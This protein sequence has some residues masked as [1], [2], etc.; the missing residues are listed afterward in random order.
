M[1]GSLET[2]DVTWFP[3]VTKNSSM[4]SGYYIAPT[5]PLLVNIDIVNNQK[6]AKELY[7]ITEI[8][9][10]PGKR[11]D[12]LAAEH[13]IMDLGVC[14]GQDGPS[15][16]D[17][18]PPAGQTK[19]SLKGSAAVVVREGWLVNARMFCLLPH[20]VRRFLTWC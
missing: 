2:S 20:T 4:N 16:L 13:R 6:E 1:A 12:V 5:D 7:M 15:G 10:L 19:W 8:E 18:H 3:K 11:K 17:V 9:Y 14:D